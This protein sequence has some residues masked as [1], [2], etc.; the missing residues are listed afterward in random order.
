MYNDDR[1]LVTRDDIELAEY[2]RLV[3]EYSND[4]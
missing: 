1:K 2:L 4:I 3:K